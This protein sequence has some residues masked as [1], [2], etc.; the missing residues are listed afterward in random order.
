MGKR[1]EPHDVFKYIDTKDNDTS[2]CWPWTGTVGGRDNRPYV[3]INRKKH[4]VPRV[5]FELFNGPIPEGKVVRHTCDN[6]QC[7]NPEHLI[8]GSRS[9][10]E[11]DKYK[12]DRAGYPR[13]VL[14]E[15]RRC[16]K[17]GMTYKAIKE[18]LD[19]KFGI[20]ISVSGIG[21]VYRGK[22]RKDS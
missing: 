21:D 14:V 15:M 13:D 20:N 1:N 19:A 18:H 22:R 5:V 8:I 9:E 11:L 16:F 10:N 4:I 6:P 2:K 12:R 17:L 3:S 7:C